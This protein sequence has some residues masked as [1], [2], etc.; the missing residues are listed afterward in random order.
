MNQTDN[1]KIAKNEILE[2]S[3]ELT[4][5]NANFFFRMLDNE[6]QE[7]RSLS[8]R[9]FLHMIPQID[10][11]YM[12][13]VVV[14]D[15]KKKATIKE[16]NGF[17]DSDIINQRAINSL[18]NENMLGHK[19]IFYL[20][21]DQ[22]FLKDTQGNIIPIMVQFRIYDNLGLIIGYGKTMETA[23]VRIDFMKIKTLA[24]LRWYLFCSIMIWGICTI[25]VVM[26]L[27]Y[28]MIRSIIRPLEKI[29]KGVSLIA[30]GDLTTRINIPNND[31]IGNLAR[32]I[33]KM[34]EDL[35]GSTISI[36]DLNQEI[37]E[38][39][40]IEKDLRL[41]KEILDKKA[42][43]SKFLYDITK[44]AAQTN[45]STEALQGCLNDFCQFSHWPI[46]HIY[47]VSEDD[48]KELISSKIW[49]IKENQDALAD[50]KRK[51]ENT[52]FIL[53]NGYAGKIWN[54]GEPTWLPNILENQ[55]FSRRDELKGTNIKGLFALPIKVQ[56]EI[57]GVVE[58]FAN[59]ATKPDEDLIV[60]ARSIAEQ[61][62]RIIE[63]K[64]A[65]KDIA[66]A[67]AQVLQSEKLA[68]I[69]QLAAGV[70]HEINNPVGFI[71]NNMELLGQYVSEYNRVLKM[72]GKLKVCVE[73]E[74]IEK[75]KVILKDIN[76]FESE[77]QLDHMMNDTE[78][79]LRDNQ[80]GIE[81]IR[82]IIKDLRTFARENN[83]LMDL[84][85]IEEV[86]DSILSIVHNELKYKAD[87]VKDY[88]KTPLVRCNTQRMGQ[89]FINLLVNAT[90][91]I[92]ERGT[93]GIK[94]YQQDKYLCIEIKDSGKGIPPENLKKIFD[95]FFTTKPVGQGTGLGLSVS[96]EIVKKH[97]G[98]I[99]VQSEVGKGTIFTV[100]LPL[101]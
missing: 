29:N 98:N 95:P 72:V 20:D 31:E 21:N 14:I 84:V 66:F 100:M 35:Q 77:I 90:H 87:L 27:I 92:E 40:Q 12:N 23:K 46:G 5:K 47:L 51:T 75:A 91:A 8:A 80:E 13:N 45:S 38:R 81:R 69:G 28:L 101:D 48:S 64:R 73:E 76:Q 53:G 62:G 86:I 22:N 97:N 43:E 7:N 25:I 89:V 2:T 60:T 16:Y 17:Q 71:S 30:H 67:Q 18:I 55:Q 94:T 82:K 34:T 65:E 44:M 9:E 99:K 93:I 83:D 85:K 74:N 42:I 41:S 78:N 36:S 56:N 19:M 1:L 70:A 10:P 15:I 37:L 54:T 63:R 6:L 88:G 61:M 26:W 58:L 57:M 4:Q 24:Y 33:N 68:S 59:E 32:S 11:D 96:Y 3:R 50:F 52:S 39:Q 49:F 79:L